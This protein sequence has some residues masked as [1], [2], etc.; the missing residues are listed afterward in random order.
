[1]WM[2]GE[3]ALLYEKKKKTAVGRYLLWVEEVRYVQL[4]GWEDAH[5]RQV[6]ECRVSR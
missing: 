1:M 5:H 4:S 6:A 3:L 2:E